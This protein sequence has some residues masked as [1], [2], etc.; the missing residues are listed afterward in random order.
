VFASKEGGITSVI[1]QTM[2][3]KEQWLEVGAMQIEDNDIECIN[4]SV[5]DIEALLPES[6]ERIKEKAILDDKYREICK[7]VTTGGNVDKG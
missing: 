6:K 4:I 1:N 2:L 3:R 7:Q 5:L